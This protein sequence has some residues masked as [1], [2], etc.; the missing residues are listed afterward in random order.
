[1]SPG[2]ALQLPAL[3][4]GTL[5]M[6]VALR[7]AAAEDLGAAHVSV[8]QIVADPG[9][10]NHQLLTLTANVSFHFEGHQLDDPACPQNP[11]R[12]DHVVLIW[13]TYG[14]MREPTH[15]ARA[16]PLAIEGITTSL[17]EDPPFRQ[18]DAL[19][20]QAK[21]P[22]FQATLVGWYFAGESLGPPGR[23]LQGGF[24]HKGCCTLFVIKQ[25]LAVS[26]RT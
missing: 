24:G 11:D 13:W 6:A 22:M 12:T 20:D 15:E 23:T 14:G 9:H 3:L 18:F 5:A 17:V 2:S 21:S 19:L 26:P 7:P 16:R 8:C 25:V 1:M 4:L 10:Y